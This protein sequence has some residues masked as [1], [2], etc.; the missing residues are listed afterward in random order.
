[1]L[2]PAL[3]DAHGD[4]PVTAGMLARNEAQP[5]GHMSSV[6]ELGAI[7]DC[8]DDRRGDLGADAFDRCDAP[9]GWISLEYGIDPAVQAV[10]PTIQIAHEV[11]QFCKRRAGHRRQRI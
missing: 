7:A 3:G 11:P 9:A 6:P 2:A 8:G 4:A 5:G 1:M 10:D